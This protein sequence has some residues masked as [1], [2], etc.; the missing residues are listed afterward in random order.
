MKQAYLGTHNPP[1]R[2]QVSADVCHGAVC[3]QQLHAH[4]VKHGKAW[5]WGAAGCYVSVFM[6]GV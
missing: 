2:W 4:Q 1:D 3:L 6:L 5:G